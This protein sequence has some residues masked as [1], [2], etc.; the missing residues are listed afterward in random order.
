MKDVVRVEAQAATSQTAGRYL[1]FNLGKQLFA[2]EILKVREIVCGL[3]VTPI[4]RAERAVRGV[5]NL[6]GKIIPVVDLRTTL[7]MTETPL[8]ERTC[9]IVVDVVRASHPAQMGVLVDAVSDVFSLKP[10]D[11][12]PAPV[13]E[14]DISASTLLGIA[15]LK[16]V[17]RILLDIQ[18]LL[19]SV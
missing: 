11:I 18:A 12:E 4:P 3:S 17:V 5:I 10:S 15:Q 1:G 6:R 13:L 16:G 2:V 14:M 19:G 7:G 9:F 8:D